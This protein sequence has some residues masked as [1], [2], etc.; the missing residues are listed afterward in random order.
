[1]PVEVLLSSVRLQYYKRGATEEGMEP[2]AKPHI[3][4]L[5]REKFGNQADSYDRRV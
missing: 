2:P 5:V 1:M 3:R 4:G